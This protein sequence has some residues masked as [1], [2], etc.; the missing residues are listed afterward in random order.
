M[1]TSI[2]INLLSAWQRDS[3]TE[4]S[5]HMASVV[6]TPL[7]SELNIR[8]DLSTQIRAAWLKIC[9]QKPSDFR[10]LVEADLGKTQL[11]TWSALLIQS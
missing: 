2:G 4:P 11:I 3:T 5:T 9:I 8:C 10:S 1:C 6:S 7:A